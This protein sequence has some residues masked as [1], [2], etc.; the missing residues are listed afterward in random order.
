MVERS[1]AEAWL[2]RL[3]PGDA[4]DLLGP[5]GQPIR[6]DRS[7]QHLLLLAED[8]AV[9]SLRPMAD[10]AITAGVQVALL[11]EAENAASV[12][13]STLLPDE[14]EYAVATRDGSVGQT[15]SVLDLLPD[16]EAWADEAIAAGSA[17]FLARV[18]REAEARDA[19]LGVASMGRRG[20]RRA[21]AEGGGRRADGAGRSWLRVLLLQT[22]GCALGVCLGC[23]VDGRS[24]PVRVCREGPI[25]DARDV[26]WKEPA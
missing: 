1:P 2:A 25:F 4:L 11:A 22:I 16:F 19:R 14:V 26:A 3:R 20:R 17:S 12:I 7:T 13:P 24:G 18:A 21:S 9:P 10:A 8:A 23:V 5:L 6:L 15:G